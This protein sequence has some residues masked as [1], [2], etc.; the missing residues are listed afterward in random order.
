MLNGTGATLVAAPLLLKTF[1]DSEPFN[2]HRKAKRKRTG[3]KAVAHPYVFL[4]PSVSAQYHRR[5]AHRFVRP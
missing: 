4:R 2:G 5:S 3:E 1:F